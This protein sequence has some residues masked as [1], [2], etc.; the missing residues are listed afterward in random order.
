MNICSDNGP[1]PYRWKR[2]QARGQACVSCR[3]GGGSKRC[4]GGG[5]GDGGCIRGGAARQRKCGCLCR[6]AALLGADCHI[7]QHHATTAVIQRYKFEPQKV[8]QSLEA[9]LKHRPLQVPITVTLVPQPLD[10][11]TVDDHIHLHYVGFAGARGMRI[12]R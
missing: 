3:N 9:V 2:D 8:A 10:C 1:H 5:H 4:R 12:V 6:S 11:L 7:I